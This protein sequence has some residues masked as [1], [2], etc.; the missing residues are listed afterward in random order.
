ML[1]ETLNS[2]TT[3]AIAKTTNPLLGKKLEEIK[4]KISSNR[5]INQPLS[6]GE[7]VPTI[8]RVC[9]PQRSHTILGVKR[10]HSHVLQFFP[11]AM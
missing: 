4:S 1:I 10:K 7:N 5:T 3:T 9:I 11:P 2:T 8:I 6:T